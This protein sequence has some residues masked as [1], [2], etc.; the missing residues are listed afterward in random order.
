MLRRDTSISGGAE[1]KLTGITSL[2]A[3]FD[4][5]THDYGDDEV[6][7][8][9]A[10]ANQLDHT[11]DVA[12]AELRYAL[13]PLT[14][15]SIDLELQ[16][17]RF[18]TSAVRDADSIRL[19]PGVHFSPDAVIVGHVAMG[20]RQFT[21]RASVLA[22]FRGLVGSANVSYTL[23]NMTTFSVDA[24]RDVMYSFEPATPY[25]LVD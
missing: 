25:F 12:G 23:L 24:T 8:G 11:S 20:F 1:L 21:P 17:D 3:S 4:R 18:D 13:T 5:T 15:V 14:T 7:L 6:F 19:M 16:R 2:I 10:L 22:G 9:T